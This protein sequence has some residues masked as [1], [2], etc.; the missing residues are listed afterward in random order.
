MK[1]AED[2]ELA[3]LGSGESLSLSR[4]NKNQNAVND[5]LNDLEAENEADDL[6]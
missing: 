4:S 3:A 6:Q 5:L 1:R 2:A